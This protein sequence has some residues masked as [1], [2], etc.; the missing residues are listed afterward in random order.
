MPVTPVIYLKS[1]Q[2][3]AWYLICYH[4]T[5]AQCR[6]IIRFFS[7]VAGSII[8]LFKIKFGCCVC[9]FHG[10]VAF[11]LC[12]QVAINATANLIEYFQRQIL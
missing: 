6:R 12:S 11:Q 3:G 1:F 8:T 9:D 2:T 7:L 5:I 4:Q 10:S